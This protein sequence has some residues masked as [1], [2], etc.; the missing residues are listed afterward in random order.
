MWQ[1]ALDALPKGELSETEKNL[2]KQ[3]EA[4]LAKANAALSAAPK[5][6]LDAIEAKNKDLP[7]DIAEEI[8]VELEKTQD[9][10]SSVCRK[11]VCLLFDNICSSDTSKRP[12][13][14]T[15]RIR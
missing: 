7:W 1:K 15:T 5:L 3:Y 10:K 2:K 4:S 14:F 6:S 8:V 12:G 11:P 13:Q 9:P